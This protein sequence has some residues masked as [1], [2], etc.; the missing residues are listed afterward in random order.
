M[1]TISMA[2][3]D[4]FA[5]EYF[6]NICGL[7]R[8]G[9]KY[10]RMREQ[11]MD[12]LERIRPQIDIKA[13][14]SEYPGNVIKNNLAEM[15][16][17]AF[18]CNAFQRMDPEHIEGVYAYVLTAGVFEL[19]EEGPFL[20]QLYADIWGTAYVDAGLAVLKQ[21]VQEDQCK[22]GET[23]EV[24]VLE[25]FGPGY[26]GMDI[27]QVS[28]FFELLD[29]GKIGVSVRGNSLMLPLKSCVGF[30]LAVDGNVTLPTSDCRS[31]LSEYKNCNFCQASV[32]KNNK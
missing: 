6:R 29:G 8:E 12:V 7:D 13:V 26:F 4:A 18:S 10:R 27:G 21:F 31:C 23:S 28:K 17:I 5:M 11:S 22:R 16:G 14:M 15:E 25:P 30:Y 24:T 9:D 20:N 2:E 3:A 1:V 32:K 19:E